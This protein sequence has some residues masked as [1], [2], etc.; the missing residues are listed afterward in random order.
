MRNSLAIFVPS[1]GGHEAA[2]TSWADTASAP[3][4]IDID[5]ATEGEAA[6]FL[7]KC[8]AAWRRTDATVIGFL[9]S[10]LTIH[11]HGWDQRV[12]AEFANDRAGDRQVGVVGFVGARQLGMDDFGKLPYK[13]TQL[14]RGDV[15]SN[16]TDAEVHG[17]RRV[18]PC[19]VAVVDSCAV[20]VRRELL[21]RCGGWPVTRY[22]NNPHCSDLWI[23]LSALRLGYAVRFVGVACSHRSG[24]KGQAGSKWLESHGGDSEHHVAAHR[25]IAEDFRSLL[26]V[27]VA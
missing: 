7:T 25:L 14:A 20:F 4:P 10:D 26:P 24:G 15:V 3:W 17:A 6:G 11:E 2:V 1:T 22:P 21:T 19:E 23:C 8:D 18:D 16:L 12:L 9:H 13:L 5:A 27:R